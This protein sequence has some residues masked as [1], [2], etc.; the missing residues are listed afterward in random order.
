LQIEAALKIKRIKKI[1][2]FFN[3]REKNATIIYD[4]LIA[5]A[6]DFNFEVAGFR[7][8]P[9]SRRLEKYL[10]KLTN[11]SLIVDAV[12][13][14][15]DSFIISN[16]RLIGSQLRAGKIMSIGA[17]KEYIDKGALM[18]TVPDYYQLGKIASAIM[19]R[20]QKGEQLEKYPPFRQQRNRY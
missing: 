11:K 20:H 9:G 18:G 4:K 1:G 17:Q 15:L 14:P 7:S 10:Q 8:P 5:I 12:Y 6:K 13:L 16:A 3:P 19:D 2:L